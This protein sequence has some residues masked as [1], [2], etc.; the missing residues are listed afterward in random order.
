MHVRST[1]FEDRAYVHLH[2]IKREYDICT[3]SVAHPL[4]I[5]LQFQKYLFFIMIKKIG[6]T[7][8]LSLRYLS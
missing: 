8:S 3:Y 1:I 4:A 5:P 2:I 7:L 6:K